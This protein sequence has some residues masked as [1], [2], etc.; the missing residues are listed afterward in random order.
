MEKHI[1]VID[2]SPTIRQQLRI[3]LEDEGFH[4]QEAE[5]GMQGLNTAK[6]GN[7]DMLIVDVNMPGMTGLEMLAELR[8]EEAH[9]T[10]P[11]FVLTTEASPAMISDG[12]KIGA[13]AWI[14]KPFKP[15]V[16]LKGIKKVLRL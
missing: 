9:K 8:K 7:F 4:V 12:K 13:T 14:V 11:A 10:T 3:C 16:L 15:R 6:K 5:D 1:L 2:D